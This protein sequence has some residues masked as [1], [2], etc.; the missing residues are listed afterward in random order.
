LALGTGFDD[1]T[2]AA[3][4]DSYEHSPGLVRD[5]RRMLYNRMRAA[6]F[7]VIACEWWHFEYGTRRWA[8]LCGREP[9]YGP[10]STGDRQGRGL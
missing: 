10:T 4:A 7:V 9:L 5:L 2:T 8:A 1:F 3:H 6:G